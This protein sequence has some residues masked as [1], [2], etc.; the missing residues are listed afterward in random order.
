LVWQYFQFSHACET[1]VGRNT[2][3][4]FGLSPYDG[5][6]LGKVSIILDT[7]INADVVTVEATFGV[8]DWSDN[9]D[10]D[11]EGTVY[12]AVIAKA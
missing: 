9:F 2:G 5:C 3:D 10:D 6:H 4:S 1:S 11:Y 7:S 8:R 12:F